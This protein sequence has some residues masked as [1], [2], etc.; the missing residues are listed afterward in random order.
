MA[1]CF[2]ER[3][4]AKAEAGNTVKSANRASRKVRS[5]R[6]SANSGDANGLSFS[7]IMNQYP[8]LSP[9]QE[10]ELINK[11]GTA[12]WPEAK[13][14]LLLSNLR[15]VKN[16]ERRYEWIDGCSLDDVVSH[17]VIGM[18]KAIDRFDPNEGTRLSTYGTQWILQEIR[19]ELLYKKGQ[20]RNPAY[21]EKLVARLKRC[22]TELEQEGIPNPSLGLLSERTGIPM[23]NIHKV[24][25]VC[26]MDMISME[27]AVSSDTDDLVV[28]D[29]LTSGESIEDKAVE[30]LTLLDVAKAIK[31]LKPIEQKIIMMRF[32]FIDG[33]PMTFA[34]CAKETGH[35]EENCRWIS[36]EAIKKLQ[37]DYLGKRRK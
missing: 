20:I 1:A 10:K 21:M 30:N 5:S 31:K 19:D 29:A 8:M 26:N 11:K 16:I 18:M 7:S 6:N 32:G 22:R 37:A 9:K 28:G 36:E 15:L 3:A 2:K 23:K 13:E 33:K 17:G 24:I 27:A 35:S 25:A 34:Q 12:E 14:K 4:A